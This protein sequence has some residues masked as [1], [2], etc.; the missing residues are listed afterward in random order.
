MVCSKAFVQERTDIGIYKA[1]GF[2]TSGL[3]AQFALRFLIVSMIGSAA[4]G[5]LSYFFSEKILGI[6]L[7]SIGIT[8][9]TASMRF[10]SFAMPIIVTCSCFL[11]FSYLVSG[12]IKKVKIRELV[13]E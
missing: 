9:F 8:N 2:Q 10:S 12:R 3:Q 5:I 1:T 11:I 13:T 7:R 6:L 4:G